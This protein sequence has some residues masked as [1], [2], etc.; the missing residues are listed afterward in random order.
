MTEQPPAATCAQCRAHFDDDGIERG[1]CPLCGKS[2][3]AHFDQTLAADDGQL[4]QI[5]ETLDSTPVIPDRTA[6][7]GTDDGRLFDRTLEVGPSAEPE[8]VNDPAGADQ[9]GASQQHEAAARA[10]LLDRAARDELPGR[11]GRRS[12]AGQT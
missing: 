6:E 2:L 5:I 7:I 1:V 3:A 11:P 4:D 12:R 9:V 10:A 8:A